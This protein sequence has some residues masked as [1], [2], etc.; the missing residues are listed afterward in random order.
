MSRAD[1]EKNCMLNVE[2]YARLWHISGI[3][4]VDRFPSWGSAKHDLS[5]GGR[6]PYYSMCLAGRQRV[7][8]A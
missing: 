1:G 3:V 4:V 5:T 8:I 7:W 6:L 2:V